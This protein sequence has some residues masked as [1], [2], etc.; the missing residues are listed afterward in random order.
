MVIANH[1]NEYSFFLLFGIRG[2]KTSQSWVFSDHFV[3]LLQWNKALFNLTSGN[4]FLPLWVRVAGPC[5]LS[6]LLPLYSR[7]YVG[8]KI[9]HEWSTLI[10]FCNLLAAWLSCMLTTSKIYL[11][12]YSS[13]IIMVCWRFLGQHHQ[14][15]AWCHCG[16]WVPD[17]LRHGITA[18][19][20]SS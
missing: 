5:I 13:V 17:L 9:S 12:M 10:F 2:N 16:L 15:L 11:S 3:A 4:K 8:S 14:C 20:V 1:G 19:L 18:L 7:N 6:E